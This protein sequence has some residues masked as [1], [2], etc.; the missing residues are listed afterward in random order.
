MYNPS[1]K[2]R[3]NIIFEAILPKLNFFERIDFARK[4]KMIAER[5]RKDNLFGR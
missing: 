4:R 3:I 5:M 2:D 1:K